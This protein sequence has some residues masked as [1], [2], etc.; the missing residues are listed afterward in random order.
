MYVCIFIKRA[1]YFVCDFNDSIAEQGDEDDRMTD[2]LTQ[3]VS[4]SERHE[5]SRPRGQANSSW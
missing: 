4:M 2:A 5:R 3:V 1:S